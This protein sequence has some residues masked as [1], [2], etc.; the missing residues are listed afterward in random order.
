MTRS[1]IITFNF[2]WSQGWFGIWKD[3]EL[4]VGNV[5]RPKT[6]DFI[7]FS[8]PQLTWNPLIDARMLAI[9]TWW[10]WIGWLMF[11]RAPIMMFKIWQSPP[12][13]L[14]WTPM[15]QT[16]IWN[17]M[18]TWSSASSRKTSSF[19]LWRGGL[20]PKVPPN[21][22][23]REVLPLISFFFFLPFSFHKS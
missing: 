11:S 22:K 1:H 4:P 15:A 14:R 9:I 18:T 10:W 21:L 5:K 7:L 23:K 2:T 16:L 19:K 3:G 6:W 20:P 17:Q 8:I 12:R 13:S